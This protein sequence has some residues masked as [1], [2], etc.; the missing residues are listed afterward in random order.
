MKIRKSTQHDVDE[1]LTV[2]DIARDYMA[3]HGNPTQWGKKYPGRDVL[4]RDIRNGSSYV[5]TDNGSIVGTC[6]FIIGTEPNYQIIKNGSWRKEKR[7]G[8]IHRLASNGK[9]K[10]IARACFDYCTAQI[11][12][13]RIDTHQDNLTMQSAILNYGFEKCGNIYVEDGSERIA[14]DYSEG[15]SVC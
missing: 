15:E 5:L 11:D 12:Y 6:S 7:Y 2:F 1:I 8:T 14:Y 3:A 13:V 10:G 9:T 4:E